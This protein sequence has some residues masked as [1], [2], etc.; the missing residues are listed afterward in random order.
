MRN[1]TKIT[2][3]CSAIM[4][5]FL[6]GHAAGAA[7]LDE[8]DACRRDAAPLIAA[9]Q[10]VETGGIPE[11]K[12]NAA[13]GDHGAALG[14]AQTHRG[15]YADAVEASPG[16]PWPGYEAAAKDPLWTARVMAAYWLRYRLATPEAR[17]RAWNGGPRF[18]DRPKAKANTAAYWAKVKA[19]LKK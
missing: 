2:L 18:M 19:Q 9:V 17:A 7:T 13:V 6:F 15:A 8:I 5:G 4:A 14:R 11:A 10:A 12:R 3:L 1:R 16:V